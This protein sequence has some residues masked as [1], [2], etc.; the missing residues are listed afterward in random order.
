MKII[1]KEEFKKDYISREAGEKLREIILVAIKNQEKITLDFA[2]LI[3]ASTSFFDE[4]IA[5]LVNEK[6]K[7]EEFNEFVTIKDI[8]RNDQKV[9]DQVTKYRGFN[10]KGFINP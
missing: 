7:P 1:I 10:I 3:I 6:I 9:L 4:G 8:N 5:K 2:D